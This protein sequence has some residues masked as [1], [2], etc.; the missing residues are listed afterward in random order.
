MIFMVARVLSPDCETLNPRLTMRR[1]LSSGQKRRGIPAFTAAMMAAGLLTNV[2]AQIQNAG[3]LLV[4]VDATGLSDGPVTSLPNNGTLGGVFSATGDETMRPTAATVGGTKALQFDGTDFLQHVDASGTP[5]FAPEGLIGEN[6][7]RSIEVWVLNPEVAGEE[8]LV[9]WGRRGGGPDGSN[10]SFNYGSDFRWGAVGHWGNRDLGWNN[11]GGSPA[12]NKWH[13]LVYTYDGTSTRVYADGELANGEFL[14]EGA[15]LTHADTSILIG[16]QTEPDGTTVTSGLRLT[17]SIGKVRIHD[18][19]LTPEQVANNYN[20]ERSA[21]VDPVIPPPEDPPVVPP[22]RLTEGPVHRYSFN[23][24]AGDASG[25]QFQDSA[26]TAN[27]SVLGAGA[28]FSGSRLVLAGGPSATAAYGD[29]PN[30]L[31]STNAAANSG[32]GQ[33]TFETWAR[34]TGS[35]TWSRV[36]DF[37]SSLA[38]PD[39]GEIFEPGGT[40]NGADY[41]MLSAQVGGDITTRRFEVRNN[42][43]P[44]GE[45]S[46]LSDIRTFTFGTDTHIVA[47]WNEATGEVNLYENGVRTG[48][49]TA[50]DTMDEINDV[51]MWLGRSQWMADQNAQV[52]FDEVRLYDV[53]LTPEQISGNT[54]SGPDHINMGQDVGA[55]IGRQPENVT[56]VESGNAT[57]QISASGSAPL[58]IQW[59]RGGTPIAGA[60]SRVLSLTNV[61]A[62]D[63]DAVFTAVVSNTVNGASTVVT[64]APVRLSVQSPVV[65]LKH[66]YSFNESTGTQV[67]DLVGTADG[68]VVGAGAFDGG[69]LTL[70]GLDSYVDL[71]NGIIT[72]LGSDGTFEMWVT[73]QSAAFWTRI[74]DFGI[75]DAGEDAQGAGV[76]TI[77]FTPRSGG[78][79]VPR[80]SANFPNMNEVANIVP[81][82]GIAGNQ[83]VHVIVSWSASGN[84]ARI[85]M[86]GEPAATGSAPQ[87]L[88][89]MNN[90]DVNNWLGRSQFIADVN[91]AG[92]FNEFRIYSGAMGPS[93]AAAS[94][95]AG[96]NA[97]PDNTPAPSLSADVSGNNLVITWPASAE[98]FALES[99]ASLGGTTTWTAV[100]GATTSGGNMQVSVPLEGNRRF[101]RLRKP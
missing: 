52:E 81:S 20:A 77:F 59:Y 57:F 28:T 55:T 29:L 83:E 68:T 90:Q 79:G 5:I 73:Q 49:F 64:S 62:A 87:P 67:E 74:F 38:S 44:A 60:R 43:D 46:A 13:H 58:S 75:S 26:G 6:P 18:G 91:W 97:L 82:T 36:F 56:T 88:S 4:N 45:E 71:P 39:T 53:V 23:E 42:E 27:G 54:Q 69:E 25:R 1:K 35:Q 9:S 63:N 12:P 17:G 16:A 41:F 78:D 11:Q 70:D 19:V 7:T 76:D 8:S 66:R 24:T 3:D 61:T 95:A 98:G 48:G 80:F 86:N 10:I 99:T 37:G 51:N 84:T 100:T 21:F 2:Q 65:T 94:F 93:Q 30:G 50:D 33:F 96:P 89:A 47:T 31:L 32:S 85:F 40:G 72:A 34:F 14:G 92:K 101:F 15:I 22:A